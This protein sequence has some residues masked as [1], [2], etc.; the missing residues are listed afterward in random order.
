MGTTYRYD[1][2]ASDADNTP[3]NPF[4]DPLT[5]SLTNPAQTGPNNNVM[6]I[7]QSGRI[8]WTPQTVDIGKVFNN[9]TVRVTDS[10]NSSVTQSFN[11]TVVADT[12]APT[13]E[14]TISPS[15]AVGVGTVATFLV[16]GSDNVGVT[17]MT[18]TVNGTNL[19]LDSK[20]QAKMTMSTAGNY[21]VTA[22][23]KDAAA[24]EV[25]TAGLFDEY[26]RAEYAGGRRIV[27]SFRSSNHAVGRQ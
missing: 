26:W 11:L 25:A 8:T 3:S 5:Y 24:Y 17:S 20:G 4:A 7:D 27:T 21:T 12:T 1:V 16:F 6:T 9:I 13:V 15:L 22:T 18:L 23:A 14:L 2:Q 10:Y 19:L